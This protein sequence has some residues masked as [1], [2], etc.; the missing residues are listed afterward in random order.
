MDFFS[1]YCE[2][3][4]AP[5]VYI[6]ITELLLRKELLVMFLLLELLKIFFSEVTKYSFL[7]VDPTSTTEYWTIS[8]CCGFTGVFNFVIFSAALNC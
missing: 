5:L 4:L 3:D 6:E 2:S 8:G 1:E 7:T